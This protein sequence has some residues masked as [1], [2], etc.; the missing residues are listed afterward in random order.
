MK[1]DLKESFDPLEGHLPNDYEFLTGRI[2]DLEAL[3]PPNQVGWESFM[4][5]AQKME[6]KLAAIEAQTDKEKLMKV[7]KEVGILFHENHDAENGSYIVL[8]HTGTNIHDDDDIENE[9]IDWDLIRTAINFD[10]NEKYTDHGC[11]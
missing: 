9:N 6:K 5:G 11:I 10:E 1:N 7:F 3:I 8:L 2:K 4:Q